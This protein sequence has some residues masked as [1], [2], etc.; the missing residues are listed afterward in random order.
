MT[1]KSLAN[2]FI[3]KINSL[4]QEFLTPD[5][6]VEIGLY[7]NKN[8]VRRALLRKDYACIRVTRNRTLIPKS[9]L[10]KFLVNA[11]RNYKHI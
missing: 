4:D 9:D 11:C 6:L 1:K 8:E 10:I 7:Q 5:N 2:P 3:D